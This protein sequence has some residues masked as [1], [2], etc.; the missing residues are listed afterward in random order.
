MNASIFAE[1]DF[2]MANAVVH[3]IIGDVPVHLSI[4]N[5]DGCKDCGLTCPV[6]K[7]SAET[8]TTNIYI[9]SSF[10]KVVTENIV[11]ICLKLVVKS[12]RWHFMILVITKVLFWLV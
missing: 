10:P 9:M 7:G 3:G 1:K 2:V 11:L 8:Y 5:P 12:V 4:P 6:K